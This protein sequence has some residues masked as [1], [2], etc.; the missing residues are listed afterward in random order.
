MGYAVAPD[1]PLVVQL[2]EKVSPQPMAAFLRQGVSQRRV[3]VPLRA[4]CQQMDVALRRD[5]IGGSVSDEERRQ[6]ITAYEQA[7]F[8]NIS[9]G[10]RVVNLAFAESAEVRDAVARWFVENQDWAA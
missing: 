8:K 6:V 2:D 9:Q 4:A 3:F 5:V 7:R 1:A 10:C